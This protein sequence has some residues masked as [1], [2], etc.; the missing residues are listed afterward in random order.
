MKNVTI[1]TLIACSFDV[2]AVSFRRRVIEDDS[3][4]RGGGNCLSEMFENALEHFIEDF[5]GLASDT[6]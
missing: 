1:L 5:L 2:L 6:G 3:N 4:G